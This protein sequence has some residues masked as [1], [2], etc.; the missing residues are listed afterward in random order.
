MLKK[1]TYERT[2]NVIPYYK[3]WNNR[4]RVDVPLKLI[5]QSLSISFKNSLRTRGEFLFSC[6]ERYEIVLLILKKAVEYADFISAEGQDTPLT[7]FLILDI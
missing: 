1:C 3:V 2:I 6:H 7:S 4:R 5:G